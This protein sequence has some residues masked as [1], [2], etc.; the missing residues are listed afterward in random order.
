MAP[1]SE[2]GQ[3]K[4]KDKTA[5][6]STRVNL[7]IPIVLSGKDSSGNEFLENTRT[8]VVSKH[9]AKLTTVQQ[10]ALGSEVTIE[11]RALARAA[12]ATVVCVGRRRFPQE[13]VE[14]GVQLFKPENIWGI[15]FPPEDWE[16]GPP[17]GLGREKLDTTSIP[18]TPAVATVSSPA[19]APIQPVRATQSPAPGARILLP[20]PA[21][22]VPPTAVTA[23]VRP[24]MPIAPVAAS[25][26]LQKQIDAANAIALAKF[27]KL[28]DEAAGTRLKTYG[29]KI[30]RFT[31]QFGLRVQ[32]N[33]QDA[34][35]RT[36]DRMVVL[37]QQ[38]LGA[39]ADRVQ[40]SRTALESL[41]A[42]FEALQKN[43][44][45]LVEV[46]EQEIREA[47]QLALQSVVQELTANLRKGVEGTSAT[48]EAECQERI[49]VA[50][51]KTVDAIL[52]KADEHLA[53]LMK[54]RLSKSS[55]ELK[56]QQAQ[57][58]GGVKEQLNQIALSATT[59]LDARLET[60]IGEIVPS[61]REEIE[62]S[63]QESAGEVVA[64]TTQSLQEQTQLLTQD[65]LGS[66]QQAVQSLQD[67]IQEE[68][69]KV[70]QSSEQEITKAAEALSQ[71]IAQRAELA[72]GS[73]QSATEQGTSKL[74]AAQFES[75]KSGRA[76]VEDY[77]KQLAARSALA[78]ESFQ[79][80]L[81]NLAWELQEGA[82]GLFSQRLQSTADE[83]A[84]DSTEKIRLRIQD[85]AAA[86]A[87]RFGKESNKRLL[88]VVD[89]FF[90]SSSQ[91]L[92]ARLRGQ[93]EAQLDP[94][95]Q[96]ASD[97]FGEHLKKLTHE[98]VLSLEKESRDE[99]QKV[100][101]TV[102]HASSETLRKEVEQVTVTLQ[103]DFKASQATVA[104]H[105]R[106]Q[107]LA[108]ARSTVDTL[109]REAFAGLDEFRA[110]LHKSAQESREESL[111]E[112][113]AS[114]QG[115]L[116]KQRATISI[117][118]QQQAEQ[119]RDHAALQI[120]TISE[121]IIAKATDALDRQGGKSTR[122]LADFGGQARV[123]LENQVQKIEMEAKNSLWEFQRQIDQSS[124][125]SLDNF[126]KETGNLLD[127]VALRLQHSVRSFQSA[128]ADEVRAELQKASDNLLEVSAGQMRKQT[129][130]TLELVTERLKEKEEE[131]VNDAAD[132]FRSRIA[133]IFAILQAGP[134]K[135]SELSDLER[136]KKQS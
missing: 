68:S 6:R 1:P 59:T 108:L 25:D 83:L 106:K 34:A 61:V 71:S 76:G 20:P 70:L 63:L 94:V 118:L 30:L 7:A 18:T 123:G 110:R 15:V 125:A 101:R 16:A 53:V 109:N 8:G 49:L 48:F 60:M 96:S 119:C 104:D 72:M 51:S 111:R 38:K 67:R 9:G 86:A 131:V 12:K 2:Q 93:A 5:R 64:R 65:A 43:T 95:I 130:Q 31:N 75:E 50:G 85:E 114:F 133:E 113:E 32:A 115:A 69:L 29:D 46:T 92:R 87:E 47:S 54:D 105:A 11:N 89:Q 102:L 90:A 80:G 10:L 78:L 81:Q 91:E 112:L 55:A 26:T 28:F 33:F 88:A 129:E 100:A 127:E 24:A 117:F 74:R 3:S 136:L 73:V 52:K 79:T 21:T 82:T 97:K 107:L 99:L 122:T 40:A 121:Q 14:I 116:E 37:I 17:I 126:R 128:T 19:P 4:A 56:A 120:K 58:I 39:L 41:L 45:T 132:V 98:G 27:T 22:R 44:E 124:N 23:P 135:T 36:E 66:L 77:Q 84:E 57:V 42:R 134:K 103:N 35:N 62:R 13:P